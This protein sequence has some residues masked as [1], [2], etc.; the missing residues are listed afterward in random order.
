DDKKL[1][2]AAIA[3][4]VPNALEEL[5]NEKENKSVAK[6]EPK[7]NRWQISTNVAPIYFSS[8]SNGSPIDSKLAQNSKDFNTDLAYGVG[9]RYSVNKNITLRTGINTIGMEQTTS[10]L[11]FTQK[12]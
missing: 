3:S 12:S 1:D 7:L 8:T 4:V 6:N 2:T 11:A 5:L 9:V 10:D